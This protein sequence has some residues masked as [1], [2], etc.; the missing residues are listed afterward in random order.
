MLFNFHITENKFHDR[1]A[2]AH[3]D[4][5]RENV[6]VHPVKMMPTRAHCS[7]SRSLGENNLQMKQFLIKLLHILM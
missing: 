2:E 3:Y 4:E 1:I 5:D 6:S 7:R